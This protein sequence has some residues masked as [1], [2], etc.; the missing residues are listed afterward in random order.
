MSPYRKMLILKFLINN[1]LKMNTLSAPLC[2]FLVCILEALLKSLI[3]AIRTAVRLQPHFVTAFSLLML[4]WHFRQKNHA[5][6]QASAES[7][8]NRPTERKII[9][10]IITLLINAV[11]V[12]LFNC[13]LIMITVISLLLI[14]FLKKKI[15][16]AVLKAFVEPVRNRTTERKIMISVI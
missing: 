1:G 4:A 9:I 5:L 16:N 8:R 14:F 10:S 6:L 15:K 3:S 2:L 13:I 12:Q 7:V 11:K